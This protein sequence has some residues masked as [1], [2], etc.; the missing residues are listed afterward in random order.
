MFDQYD[1]EGNP[2]PEKEDPHTIVTVWKVTPHCDKSYDYCV[3]RDYHRA[4]L[5]AQSLVETIMDD[6]DR[7]PVTIKIETVQMEL[8][9][10]WSLHGEA[11]QPLKLFPGDSDGSDITQSDGSN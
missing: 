10:Y 9:E 4:M 3:I 6:D 2:L 8:F 7:I 11:D 1:F 5:W